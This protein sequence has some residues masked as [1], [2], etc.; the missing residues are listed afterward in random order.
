M[1][2]KAAT[3]ALIKNCLVA[4]CNSILTVTLKSVFGTIKRWHLLKGANFTFFKMLT[5]E[6]YRYEH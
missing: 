5:P 6:H 3:S 2:T 4:L 1:Q